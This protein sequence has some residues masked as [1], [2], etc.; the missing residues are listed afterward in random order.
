MQLSEL[1]NAGCTTVVG[2]TGTDSISRSMENL[3]TKVRAIN[4]EGLTAYMWTGAYVLPAPTITGSVMRDVC[5]IES[6]IG[7]G[8]VAV[9][10]HRGSQPTVQDLERLAS[11]C[12]VGGM[13]GGK[14]GKRRMLC[15]YCLAK[16][17][18]HKIRFRCCPCSYGHWGSSSRLAA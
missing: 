1:V 13:L 4:E 15:W 17:D 8:E 3:L 2:V 9:A 18:N 5:L 12:R 10:D 7:V 11:E 16:S 6:C 14:A